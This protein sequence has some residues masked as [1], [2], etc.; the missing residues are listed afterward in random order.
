MAQN[1]PKSYVIAGI[2][3][4]GT[5]FS[6]A[7][8]IITLSGLRPGDQITIPGDS[9]VQVAAKNIWTRKQFSYVDIKVDKVSPSGI[10][11]VINVKEFPRLSSININ[12]N[13]ELSDEKINKA[14]QKTRG[15]ILSPYE[16]YLAK[17]R[18]LKLYKEE[19]MQFAKVTADIYKTDTANYSRLVFEIEEGSTFYTEKIDFEGNKD[20][21][22]SELASEFDDT[23]TK[24]WWQ[25]WRSS[26]FD[27]V[28]YKLD[29]ELLNAFFK[30]KGYIDGYV[31]KDTIMYDV[32]TGK[33]R[34]KLWVNEGKKF[35][36]RNVNFIGNTVYPSTTLLRR[37]D[38][39]KGDVYDME[40]FKYNLLGNP[41]STDA[42]SA[43][44][45]NGYLQADMKTEE[46]RIEPDSIDLK[47]TVNENNRITIRRV[48]IVGN[49][50]T[51]DKVIRRE[52][53]TQPGD[54]FNKSAVIRSVRALSVLN[55]FNP[56]ALRPNLKMVDDSKIDLIYTV[57]E[58]STDQ[59]NL[60]LGFAGVYGLTGS[61]GLVLNNFSLTEPFRGGAGQILNLTCEFGTI[62][63][64]QTIS[65]GF[66]EPWLFDDPTTVG[67]NI[68]DSRMNYY[69][70]LHRTGV[71]I[72]FGRRFHWPDDYFRG[73]WSLSVQRNDVGT[74]S[75]YYY[76][77]G[78]ST[79]ITVG[80]TLSRISLDN[81]AFP[82]VGSKFS[83]T[84]NMA[85]GALGLGNT[86]F[87]KVKFN[88]EVSQP[89]LQIDGNNRLILYLAT[90][91]GYI[92]GINSDTTITPY[93][94]FYMGGNGLNGIGV[95]PLRGYDDRTVG[96]YNGG[97]V[98]ARHIAELRFALS[99][100]PMPI[101]IFGF[102]EAGNVWASLSK[103]DPFGLSRSAGFGLQMMIN[104]IGILGFSYGY[105]FD[106]DRLTG[107]RSGWKF[108]FH[109]GTQ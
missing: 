76:R 54:F 91:M 57:E 95:T 84:T 34:L 24:H 81:L 27:P 92:T 38:F 39:K 52:L 80:Q 14:V 56:E 2:S 15:D 94:L 13:N 26:K 18:I 60:S 67:F 55:Y 4:E 3:V 29:K 50:K 7:Q 93:E 99:L 65:L 17:Q 62:S 64:M 35:Y 53:F 61:I 28:K 6:D 22:A 40:K 68:F 100:D 33:V 104:P 44:N 77:E 90:T 79:E 11:L 71:Q 88:F 86:D 106:I 82:T 41:E 36:V 58:R 98:M 30:K 20:F 45:D 69:Y 32:E 102:A 31:I 103:T 66:T 49:N 8:T 109:L 83:I 48:E 85:L 12:N 108:L 43:Y 75:S 72:N 51:K 42:L 101:F 10:F 78:I 23:H 97:R 74:A 89:L 47:I 16:V 96:E 105:G 1:T 63:S 37:L 5:Q 19:G 73:D 46:T 70:K 107:V 87:F 9:K 21:T 59:I 25:F